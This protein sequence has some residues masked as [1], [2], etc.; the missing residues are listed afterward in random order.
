MTTA[1]EERTNAL[2]ERAKEARRLVVDMAASERGC[3]LG[4]SLSAM[5]LLIAALD[6]TRDEESKVVLSKGHAAAGLYAALH[7]MGI[8]EEDPAPRY[9]LLGHPYTGHP[10]P[11]VPGVSFPTGSLGHGLPYAAGWA[12]AQRLKGTGGRAVAIVGDG[13]LQEGL[14]WETVQVAAARALGNLVILVDRN[15]GQ[16][17]GL[18]GD[19]SPLPHLAERFAAFGCDTAEVDG[20]DLAALTRTLAAHDSPRPLAVVA[21]TVKGKGVRAVE[22]KAASHYVVIDKARAEKWKKGIR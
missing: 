14:I 17:D 7:A 12:L 5:D 3:H 15:G 18:V 2:E 19:I 13:E 6:G 21:N 10:G 16:N 11:K 9:G 20:H 22:G 1:T 4:G 8:L